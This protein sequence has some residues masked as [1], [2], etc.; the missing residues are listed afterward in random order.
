MDLPCQG[1]YFGGFG[2]CPF[3]VLVQKQP[4][5]LWEFSAEESEEFVRVHEDKSEYPNSQS[6]RQIQMTAIICSQPAW[7]FVG[8]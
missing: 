5:N 7:S 1:I 3:D 2:I 8:M 4:T 6:T